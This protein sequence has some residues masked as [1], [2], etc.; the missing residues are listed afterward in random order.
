MADKP[1]YYGVLLWENGITSSSQ[2]TIYQRIKA[3]S[4]KDAIELALD[5]Y[6]HAIITYC[7]E[8]NVHGIT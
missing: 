8:E 4:R 2:A 7:S 1:R 6:P 5:K 3:S